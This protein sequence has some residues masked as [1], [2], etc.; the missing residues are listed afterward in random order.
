MVLGANRP[1][2]RSL[3]AL[4]I[5]LSAFC[6]RKSNLSVRSL[7]GGAATNQDDFPAVKRPGKAIWIISI[8]LVPALGISFFSL[9]HDAATGYNQVWPVFLFAGVAL[10]CTLFWSYLVS[11]LA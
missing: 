8:M 10:V 2:I 4:A 5:I 6:L 9:Y 3:S 11:Q 1:G 7:A